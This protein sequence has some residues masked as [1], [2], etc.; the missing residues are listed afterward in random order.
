MATSVQIT[1]AENLAEKYGITRE[2]AIAIQAK[3]GYNMT[4]ETRGYDE[5]DVDIEGGDED[6]ADDVASDPPSGSGDVLEGL[7][8][9]R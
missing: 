7:L 3:L 4:Y 5:E 2:A 1:K 6:Y 8:V 9:F